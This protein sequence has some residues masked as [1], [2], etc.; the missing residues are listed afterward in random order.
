MK[1]PDVIVVGGGLHGCSAA[2]NLAIR[3]AAVLLLEKDFVGRHA[4]GANAGGVRQI[5]RALPEIPLSMAAMDLWHRIAEIVDDD[6]GFICSGHIIVAES[7]ADLEKL[8]ERRNALQ[9][10]GFYH[11]EV[12][13]DGELRYLLPAVADHCIGGLVSRR[14]GSASPYRTVCA[15]RLKAER[16]GVTV[17]EGVAVTGLRR[18]NNVWHVTLADGS[19]HDAP[20]L[21]NAAGAWAAELATQVGER[22]PLRAVAP[23]LMISDRMPP[24]VGPVVSAASQPLSFKQFANGTVLI[25]GGYEGIARPESNDTE[26]DFVKLARNAGTATRL[27][28]LMRDSRIVRSWAAIEGRMIDDIPVIGAS[29]TFDGLFHTFGYSAHGFQLGPIAGS[30]IADLIIDGSTSLPI[31]P[32][33]ITRFL[34]PQ[35]KPAF[36]SSIIGEG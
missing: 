1:S 22:P 31:S 4:S 12:M 23:M 17:Q 18:S 33:S 34:W 35:A 26:L 11:E 3:G 21:V 32:F 13:D 14:D 28:P 36:G 19:S 29:G 20:V 9:S 8:R 30:I 7:A 15:Y 2:L 16:L 25:G 27:F 5:G 6:C 10:M 24:F